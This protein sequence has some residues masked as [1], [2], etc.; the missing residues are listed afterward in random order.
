[1]ASASATMAL[2]ISSATH[3]ALTKPSSGTPFM[4]L[5]KKTVFTKAQ[6]KSK[7]GINA[8]LKEKVVTGLTAASLTA[9]MVLPEVAHAAGSDLSPSLKNFLLSIFAGGAVL[10]AILGAVIGVSNFDPVRRT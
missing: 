4:P 8:S 3:K 5:P 7:V 1:M 10:T 9:S 2:P 6:S